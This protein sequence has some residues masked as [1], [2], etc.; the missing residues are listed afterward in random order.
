MKNIICVVFMVVSFISAN[1][2][3]EKTEVSKVFSKE[4]AFVS[5][6]ATLNVFNAGK[7]ALLIGVNPMFGY[8]V[9]EWLDVAAV[10]NLQ[11]NSFEL[12][13]IALQNGRQKKSTLIGLGASSRVYPVK[14]LYLQVQPELNTI[15]A[16][17]T[18]IFSGSG[19]AVTTKYTNIVPS[20]LVG[21]G[22]KRG[23]TTGKTFA[24]ASILFDVLANANSPYRNISITQGLSGDVIPILRFG[25]NIMLTDLQKK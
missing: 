8:Y 15:F 22:M 25:F 12:D 16:K 24:W 17:E 7:T 2:Q 1:A 20:L 4:N 21:A 11:Y 10:L 19:T 3:M 14:F 23:F 13:P 6:S 9:K 18:P 5:G